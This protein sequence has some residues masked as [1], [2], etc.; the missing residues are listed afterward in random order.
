M[1]HLAQQALD[2]RAGEEQKPG[3]GLL[4]ILLVAL[5]LFQFAV[6]CY[7][8]LTQIRNHL[9]YDSSWNILRAALV[10]DEK[11]LMGASWSET[12]NL[13]LDTPL[14]IA[15]LLYG[16]TGNLLLSFGLADIL[17]VGLLLCFV[18]KIL[19]R[20]QVKTTARLLAVN[21]VVCPYMTT[22]FQTF[23]DLGY[24]SCLLSGA[25]YYSIRTLLVLMIIYEFLKIVQDQ[26]LGVLGWLLWPLCLLAGISF[27]VFLIII[28][29]IPYLA[30]EMEMAAIRNDWK[31]L[32]QKESIFAYICCGCVFLGKILALTV[33]HFVAMDSSRGWTSLESLWTNFGAVFQGFM[34]LL[35]VLPE[36][37]H[38]IL[39]PTGLLRVFAI[40]IFA[41]V[42]T[43]V[44]SV[45]RRA[46][47]NPEEKSGAC[48]FLSNVV[49][50]NFLVF[51]LF[52]VR[53]G[54][55]IFEV[56]YLI[57]TFLIMILIVALFFDGLAP[58]RVGTGMLSLMLSGSLLMVD[59][60]SDVNYL[61]ETNAAWQMDEIQA[62]AEAQ[63]AGVVYLWGDDLT[64]IGR[65]L[66]PCDLKR[67]YKELPD[68]GG[69]FIHWGDYTTY[70]RQ[71]EY[72]GPTLLICP[73]EK[74]LVPA[75]IL[76]EYTLLKEL[77]QVNVYGSNHNPKLF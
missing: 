8:N 71:E 32:I 2:R 26:K 7:F 56:R 63:E 70:D 23:N 61:R 74:N 6:I 68:N 57:P 49:F 72:I 29:F 28:L 12:T 76:S 52:N 9:G 24:F 27:G 42:M 51:G 64:V 39:S 65:A 47:R 31:Q 44:V 53:Y 19:E 43:A 14:L 35:Q 75:S 34:Q 1:F 4:R 58:H 46:R 50:F 59:V 40:L 20:L 55:A 62:L 18:W 66:R 77:D 37:V 21:M 22:G 3:K 17:A 45:F 10:W 33:I 13:H 67:V 15:S 36:T 11:T 38:A 30:Y 41:L 5:F 16:L 73:Q 60:H 69:F 48:L 25:S 54:E